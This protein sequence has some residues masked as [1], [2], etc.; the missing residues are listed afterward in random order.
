M[1]T[2]TK[3]QL[4][5]KSRSGVSGLSCISGI[6]ASSGISGINGISGISGISGNNVF[7]GAAKTPFQEG[8]ARM[9]CFRSVVQP[10]RT[11]TGTRFYGSTKIP[12]KQVEGS[13]FHDL[14]SRLGPMLQ[15]THFNP[16]TPNNVIKSHL[17]N[18]KTPNNIVR[19]HNTD[20]KTPNNNH[21]LESRLGNFIRNHDTNPKT[22]SNN[23][24]QR[25]HSEPTIKYQVKVNDRVHKI[26]HKIGSGGSAKVY[27]GSDQ[28]GR[29]VAIK[30]I[31]MAKADLKAQES[32]FNEV[33]LLRRLKN[34]DHVV[35]IHDSE[36][37]S[38]CK[39]LVIVMEKG[40]IDYCQLIDDHLKER[41]QIDGKFIKYHWGLMVEAVHEIHTHGIVHADLK[42]VNFILVKGKL[43]LIDFGIASAVDPGGTSVVRDYQIGTI[44]YMAPET[45]KNRATDENNLHIKTLIKYNSKVDIWSLGCILY[46]LVYGRPPFDKYQDVLSKIH[47]I[48]NPRQTIEYPPLKNPTLMDC[49]KACLRYNP[50]DRP[51]AQELLENPYLRE[52][53]R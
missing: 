3:P 10:T 43:K 23:M 37:K 4:S 53:V 27:A 11:K 31:N 8:N 2:P 15:T 25:S 46:Y 47:A 52:E 30:I 50:T 33:E 32:Y 16:K 42:P 51:S 17:T 14:A 38:D 19:T 36:Y 22:P 49:L 12:R 28:S 44:N 5:E 40:E 45:L 13:K 7:G 26:T 21:E 48:T 24:F 35:R 20:P 39:E 9:R 1:E 34:S 41:K 18:H 29:T 6:N